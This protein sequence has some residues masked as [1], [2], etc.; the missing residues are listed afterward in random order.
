MIPKNILHNTQF[1]TL[2]FCLFESLTRACL[3]FAFIVTKPVAS[4]FFT[5]CLVH[6]GRLSLLTIVRKFKIG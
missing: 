3:L 2:K 4:L 5:T 6:D 1:F